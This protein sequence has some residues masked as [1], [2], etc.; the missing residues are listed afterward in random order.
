MDQTERQKFH[1]DFEQAL[2]FATKLHAEQVRKQTDIPY[3]SHLIGVSG[4]VLENGGTRDEAIAA[5]LHDSIEDQSADYPGGPHALRKEIADKFGSHVLEIVEGCTDAETMPKPPW[6]ARKEKYIEH[7]QVA[8]N[9]IRLVSCAD[10]LH[11]ARAIV[12]DLRVMGDILW[13]RFTG[14]KDGTLWYYQ[15]LT[16]TFIRLGPHKLAKELELTVSE[17]EKLASTHP[18]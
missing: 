14:G 12:N 17:M 16:G 10:K 11:N 18:I 9:S 8:S 4:I 7:L 15:S 2:S 6:R 1:A 13:T 3:I 5:L